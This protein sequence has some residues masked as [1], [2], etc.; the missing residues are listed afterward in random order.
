MKNIS[1]YSVTIIWLLELVLDPKSTEEFPLDAKVGSR[2]TQEFGISNVIRL[3]E[4][5]AIFQRAYRNTR[6]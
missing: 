4:R 5:L 6:N 1:S 3:F 2:N